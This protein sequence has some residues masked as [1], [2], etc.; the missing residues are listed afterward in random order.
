[1]SLVVLAFFIHVCL[2]YT[3]VEGH[4][5]LGILNEGTSCSCK[6]ASL[7]VKLPPTRSDPYAS[8]QL[9]KNKCYLPPRCKLSLICSISVTSYRLLNSY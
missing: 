7:I 1:M 6:L 3:S 9:W 2:L 5:H 8:L 4:G